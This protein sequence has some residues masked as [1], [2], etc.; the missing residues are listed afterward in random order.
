VRHRARLLF[1]HVEIVFQVEYL[2]TAA[3]AALATRDAFAVVLDLDARWR[4]AGGDSQTGPEWCRIPV[5]FHSDPTMAVHHQR[6][7]DLVNRKPLLGQRQQMRSLQ[8]TGL[9]HRH[10]SSADGPVATSDAAGQ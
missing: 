10:V 6:E 9:A 7:Q 2:V 3:V 5:G 4:N 8:L 1:Q